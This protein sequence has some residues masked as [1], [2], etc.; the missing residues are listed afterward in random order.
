[1]FPMGR[2]KSWPAKTARSLSA[3]LDRLRDTLDRLHGRLREAVA[4]AVGASVA[5]AA[6]D[7]VHAALLRP[8]VGSV[9]DARPLRP[10]SRTWDDPSYNAD[11]W[12]AREEDY[13]SAY[14]QGPRHPKGA[15]PPA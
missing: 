11:P 5:G 10:S 9:D 1:E 6:Q 13:R 8:A 7:A 2:L 15:A 3:R 12:A 14:W 4:D